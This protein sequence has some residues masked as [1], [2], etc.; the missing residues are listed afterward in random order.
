MVRSPLTLLL[1]S[2]VLALSPFAHAADAAKEAPAEEAKE[3]TIGS[4]APPIDIEHWMSTGDGKFQAFNEFEPGKVYVVEFWA[5]WC[6]PCIMSM[7]H[8]VDLQKRFGDQGVTIVSVSDE[9]LETVEG[10]LKRDVMQQGGE[11]EAAEGE[12]KPTYAELTS[13]YCLTTDPDESVKKDYFQAAGQSGIPCA[14]VVGKD[15]KI[16]WIGHPMGMDEALEAVVAGTWDREAFATEFKQTQMVGKLANNAVRAARDGD[17]A[18]FDELVKELESLEVN[19]EMA[20]QI[21]RNVAQLKNMALASMFTN[22]PERAIAELKARG[23]DLGPQE[24]VSLGLQIA[25]MKSRGAEISPE[26]T[27]TV[28]KMLEDAAGETPDAISQFALGQLAYAGGDVDKAITYLQAASASEG[29]DPRM[30]PM[31]EQ[32]IK[33][34]EEEK[35]SAAEAPAEN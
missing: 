2:G 1:L 19:E 6:G 30:K 16:E 11:A 26:L 27:A 17:Y 10:F 33:K 21:K 35:A 25:Q 7:P 18:K 34:W 31:I 8:L 3:M 28:T 23:S 5:T 29:I 9:P 4:V 22:D 13:A 32:T 14:F 15:G 20:E 24:L 12:A